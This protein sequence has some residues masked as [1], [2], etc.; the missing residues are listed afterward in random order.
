MTRFKFDCLFH[1]A[2][3]ASFSCHSYSVHDDVQLCQWLKTADG[4]L[5]LGD[6]NRAWPMEYNE[7]KEKYC[8]YENGGVAGNVSASC[9]AIY[10][11]L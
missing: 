4:R 1:P 9:D 7:K 2:I 8:K 10:E 11:K 5:K 3:I 6:F